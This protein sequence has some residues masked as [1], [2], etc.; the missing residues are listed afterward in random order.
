MNLISSKIDE[1]KDDLIESVQ[2]IIRIK[3]VEDEPKEGMPFGEGVSKSLEC[4]LEISKKLGFKV[5]NL[6]GHVGYAEYGDGEEYV[7][8][9]GHL[10]VV[11]EGDDWIYPAYGSEIHDGK[12]YGRGTTDDKGPIMASLYGL[13]AIKELG[14]PLSKKIRIIFGTNEETGSKDIEYYLEHEKAPVAGFTP[15]AE[16]PIIN[17]EKGI[18]IFDIVKT[19]EEKTTD[20]DVLVESIKGGIASNVVASLCETKLKAKEVNKVCE[21]I[22]KFAKE[23]NIKFEVSHKNDEIELKV[24]GVSAHGSTP[25]KGI[26]AIMQTIKILAELNLAQEDIKA[27]VKLLNDN[28]GEDVYGEKFGILL[29]DEASGKLSFNVG[30]IDLND[31]VGRLTLNLR[32][33]VTKTLDDMMTPFNERIKGTGIEIENFEHQKPLYFSPDHPLIKTLK[34]V[35]KEET[36]K[37][38]ELMSIGGG[39]YAKEMPNIVAFGP[40]FPGEPDVIHKPNEYIKIDDL[41]LISK[42]YAKALYELAK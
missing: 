31:K 33:P 37:E 18:T 22:S 29:Q 26:N 14:L 38:G 27:F 9:L 39:T 30:V 24:F 25:E 19:F 42:I 15:D 36:G 1:M 5:V 10:D 8:A 40:I 41:I 35:Y 16:F 11:P 23:N 6:D 17:G 34:N 4:A 2:N 13:K 3:S 21:E 12:I 32:Y 7:A 20:G 28:I